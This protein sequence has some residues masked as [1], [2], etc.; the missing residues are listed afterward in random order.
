MTVVCADEPSAEPCVVQGVKT[1]QVALYCEG[2]KHKYYHTSVLY[3]DEANFDVM[4]THIPTPWSADVSALVSLLKRKPLVVTYHNDLTGQGVGGLIARL[5][6][7]TFLHLVLLRATRIII[8]Q[9]KYLEYSKYLKLYKKKLITLPPGVTLPQATDGA[10][11]K[12]DHIAFM[13]VL[14][15]YHEYKGLD[16]LLDAMVKV[17]ESR[18]Q[19]WL[20]VGGE[21]E[22]I[23][24]Y[25]Q[26]AMALGVSNS[27]KFLGYLSDEELTELY[28]SSSIFVLPSL[29]RL[30][31]FGIVALEA[32]SYA[33][34][35]ITTSFAG[36][37]EFITK[38]KAGLIVPPGDAAALAEAIVTLLEDCEGARV[39][40]SRGAAAV[41]HDFSWDSIALQ[42]T[43]VYRAS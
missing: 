16:I 35:V 1:I 20:S 17:K 43:A 25:K 33:T 3:A 32:L 29:N 6:N 27:V 8:T 24:K 2:R 14:D 10:K 41:N 22:L 5:Y 4:H 36:S 28:S 7:C 39:M 21:G 18:P 42:T 40:G 31:G 26:L 37:A 13:S 19:V 9:P 23:S 30:E 15:R 38:N 34:P 11:R 12:A